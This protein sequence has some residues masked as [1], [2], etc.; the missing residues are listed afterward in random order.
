[1]T[2]FAAPDFVP[3]IAHHTSP[4]SFGGKVMSARDQLPV[5]MR[6]AMAQ[7]GYKIVH[8]AALPL[9]HRGGSRLYSSSAYIDFELKKIFIAATYIDRHGNRE[10]DVDI[11][12]ALKHEAGHFADRLF[13][14]GKGYISSGAAFM[15]AY[16]HD[17]AAIEPKTMRAAFGATV[18]EIAKLTQ[19]FN[20]IF[21]HAVTGRI[22]MYAELWAHLHDGAVSMPDG[23]VN[24]MPASIALVKGHETAF[25]DGQGPAPGGQR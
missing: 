20:R 14:G 17:M 6:A 25:L 23:L 13:A 3:V 15:Q 18:T 9:I 5:Y 22:E 11:A 7:Q 1:M 4:P 19:H 12:G 21:R 10:R 16:T 2:N 24:L 8:G